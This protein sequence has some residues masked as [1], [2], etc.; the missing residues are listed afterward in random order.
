MQKNNSTYI[1]GVSGGADSMCM[2]HKFMNE[3]IV[4]VH[5][6]HCL[7]V[8]ADRDERFVKE[9][10]LTNSLTFFSRKINVKNY[11][12]ENKISFETAGRI[13]RYKFFAEIADKYENPIIMTAH[14]MNDSVESFIMHLQRG[15][16]LS[17]LCGIRG[18]SKVEIL[19]KVYDIERP[20]INLSRKEIEKYNFDNDVPYIEDETNSDISFARNAVRHQIMPILGDI[21]KISDAI[22]RIQV[23]EDY[24]Q[25][26]VNDLIKENVENYQFSVIWFNELHFAI[27]RRIIHILTRNL[28]SYTISE[29][30]IDEAINVISKNYGGKMIQFPD[31]IR[32]ELKKGRVRIFQKD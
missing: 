7:R 30:R 10:C 1:L 2:L 13:L 28:T 24:L 16:S 32:I 17:G 29:E 9:Y 27:K 18:K 3:N 4:A 26:I 5:L 11:A 6:N 19:N 25:K 12:I 23:D 20:L 14:N 22:S 21:H 15:A 8:I 31:N